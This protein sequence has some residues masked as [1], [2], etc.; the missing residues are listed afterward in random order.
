MAGRKQKPLSTDDREVWRKVAKSTKPLRPEEKAT[1]ADLRAAK[2]PIIPPTRTKP[3]TPAVTPPLP[4]KSPPSRHTAMDRRRFEQLRR[5]KL[6]PQSRIDL[7]GLTFARARPE[8]LQFVAD[9]HSRGLR[10]ILV[11]TGKG[12]SHRDDD[13]IMPV[14]RGV[15]RH[16]VPQWLGQPPLA[17]LVLQ[18]TQAHTRHGGDGA[19]YVYLR[20]KAP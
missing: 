3:A 8:L 13:S 18:V 11:I 1:H 4:V 16:A 10:L 7:H 6:S 17:G 5:G 2:I 15:L 19:Y 12:N 14:R 9:A 20:R